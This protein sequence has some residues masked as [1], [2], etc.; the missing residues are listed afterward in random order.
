MGF[1]LTSHFYSHFWTIL[2]FVSTTLLKVANSNFLWLHIAKSKGSLKK[3]EWSKKRYGPSSFSLICSLFLK[4]VFFFNA[5]CMSAPETDEIFS[6]S[7]HINGCFFLLL[8]FWVFF[9]FLN[10][11][12]M[13]APETKAYREM[14]FS[15]ALLT[16]MDLSPI[17][18][19]Y[20][21]IVTVY[22][23][24]YIEMHLPV[25]TFEQH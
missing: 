23:H 13:F 5:A 6:G 25:F 22:C 10:T 15:W 21:S 11:A 12:C 14:K 2:V 18:R 20:D 7:P 3:L 1:Y 16:S 4:D 19:G 9:F 24:V 17:V 8:F